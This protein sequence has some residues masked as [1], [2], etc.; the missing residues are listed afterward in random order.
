MGLG[1]QEP[2]RLVK[3]ESHKG[4]NLHGRRTADSVYE[5]QILPIYDTGG[6]RNFAS[7]PYGGISPFPLPRVGLCRISFVRMIPLEL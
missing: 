3:R 4:A 5:Y 6:I 2:V 1:A 7:T